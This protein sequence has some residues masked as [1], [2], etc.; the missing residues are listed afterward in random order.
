VKRRRA[1]KAQIP[2]AHS[3][4]VRETLDIHHHAIANDRVLHSVPQA[5][6]LPIHAFPESAISSHF[7]FLEAKS[8]ATHESMAGF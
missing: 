3:L 5:P 1:A 6:E 7:C 2:G 4:E 8:S